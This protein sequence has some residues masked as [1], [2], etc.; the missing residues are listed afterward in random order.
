MLCFF[1]DGGAFFPWHLQHEIPT[2]NYRN[3][4]TTA[5][6]FWTRATI[7]VHHFFAEVVQF[8]NLRSVPRKLFL[9]SKTCYQMKNPIAQVQN[10]NNEKK[11]AYLSLKVLPLS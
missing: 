5:N 8:G 1:S 11:T 2:E 10:E 7:E 3:A 4:F 9:E 6:P